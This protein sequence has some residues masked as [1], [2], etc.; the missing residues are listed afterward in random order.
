MVN[1][2]TNGLLSLPSHLF[3]SIIPQLSARLVADRITY[4]DH[5]IFQILHQCS[6]DH[7]HHTLYHLISLANNDK[8][9]SQATQEKKPRTQGALTLLHGLKRQTDKPELSRAVGQLSNMTTILTEFAT[10]KMGGPQALKLPE[11]SI[12]LKL[13]NLDA[14]QC[15]TINLPISIDCRYERKITTIQSWDRDIEILHGLS[16]PKKVTANCSDGKK[17]ALIVKGND[18]LHQDAVMQQ[19]FFTINTILKRDQQARE[20]RLSI[21]TYK[22]VPFSAKSGIIE[23]CSN[24]KPIGAVIEQYHK[25]YRPFAMSLADARQKLKD[26]VTSSVDEK[27][28]GYRNVIKEITPVFQHFFYEQFPTPGVWFERKTF[29]TNSVATNSMIGYILGIGDRHV[30]K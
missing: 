27:L 24:T 9:P 12:L 17:Y 30:N 7:P 26:L 19:V 8:D 15:P 13:L 1:N 16:L 3:I 29:Y 20:K 2:K 21:R 6:K 4:T 11:T 23:F 5:L 10:I 14:I 25:K 18:D 22:V 28:K